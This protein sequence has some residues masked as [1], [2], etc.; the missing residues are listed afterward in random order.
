VVQKPGWLRDKKINLLAQISLAKHPDLPDVPLVM[1]FAKSDSDRQVLEFLFARNVLGRPFLA[2]P[3]VPGER[4]VAL[5]AA[6]DAMVKDKDVIA[7]FKKVKQELAP[8]GGETI[9]NL[10][11]R[12]YATPKDIIAKARAA[13]TWHGTVVRPTKLK[14]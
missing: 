4:V 3:G 5:R 9:Q 13:T 7:E 10:M 11:G 8:V 2:P 1:E 14:K 6:F 12:L